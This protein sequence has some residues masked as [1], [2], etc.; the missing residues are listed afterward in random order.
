MLAA[1]C[2]GMGALLDLLGPQQPTTTGGSSSVAAGDAAQAAEA[3]GN[4]STRGS[5]E[6]A[7]GDEA[8]VSAVL[9]GVGGMLCQQA[10][11][12]GVLQ[13]KAAPVRRAGLS[14]VAPVA[15]KWPALLQVR[16][17]GLANYVVVLQVR[18][19]AAA[20]QGM[21]IAALPPCLSNPAYPIV[22]VSS[23]V[24]GII[25]LVPVPLFLNCL[26]SPLADE[27]SVCFIHC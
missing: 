6:G 2:A 12:K 9:A 23:K 11:L 26:I 5:P 21:A 8:A 17:E 14:L 20:D 15:R 4:G 1:T 22:A 24:K 19:V 7:G 25:L 27:L 13:S 16:R 10:F 3:A 18:P